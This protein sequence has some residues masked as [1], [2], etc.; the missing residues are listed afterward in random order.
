MSY[1]NATPQDLEE[2]NHYWYELR[3]I[4]DTLV[5]LI[6]SDPD[7]DSSV[8]IASSI[9]QVV[10]M[11]AY[12]PLAMPPASIDFLQ[13]KADELKS[14]SMHLRG[15][16]DIILMHRHEQRSKLYNV[17][18]HAIG[19]IRGHITAALARLRDKQAHGPQLNMLESLKQQNDE[20]IN[21]NR[22]LESVVS[23]LNDEIRSIK[24]SSEEIQAENKR[25]TDDL[26]SLRDE[27]VQ[28]TIKD[29]TNEFVEMALAALETSRKD[30]GV[31]AACWSLAALITFGVGITLAF[32]FAVSGGRELIANKDIQWSLIAFFSVKGAIFVGLLVAIVKFCASQGRSYMHESLKSA[33][34]KHAIHYGKFY[35]SVFG[36]NAGADNVK[37]AFAHWNI[38]TTSAF[39]SERERHID[40]GDETRFAESMAGKLI[41]KIPTVQID[42]TT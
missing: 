22:M 28:A 7:G 37:E 33:E 9:T 30:F 6:H 14:M 17:I 39:L 2:A 34:R 38:S 19:E 13:S 4:M 31:Y 42:K 27:S 20:Q 18:E 24:T 12:P 1:L 15:L 29:N 41:E 40:R 36:T 5:D 23:K 21:R 25:L 8:D 35:M 11:L 16:P 26:K 10:T 32:G 3:A